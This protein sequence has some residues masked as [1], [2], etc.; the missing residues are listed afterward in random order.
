M[1]PLK[2]EKLTARK[3]YWGFVAKIQDEFS[4]QYI[5]QG[6][7]VKDVVQ[8]TKLSPATVHRFL[9]RGDNLSKAKPYS[10]LHGPYATTIFAIG[11]ALGYSFKAVRKRNA[12]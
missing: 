6:L 1:K 7:G 4:A 12:S 10:F 9:H 3:R 5:H 8:A 2:R 11:D